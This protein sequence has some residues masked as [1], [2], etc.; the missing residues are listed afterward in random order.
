MGLGTTKMGLGTTKLILLA[1]AAVAV[2][3]M[4]GFSAGTI[5]TSVEA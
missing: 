2:A 4:V 5:I 1:L 3:V